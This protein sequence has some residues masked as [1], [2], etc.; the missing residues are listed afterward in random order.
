M[1]RSFILLLFLGLVRATLQN[2]TVDDASPDIVYD[3]P[4]FQCN[5]TICPDG[6]PEGLFNKSTTLTFGS[7][8]FSFTGTAFYGFLDLVGACSF[9]VDGNQ[10]PTLNNMTPSDAEQET[11]IVSKSDMANGPHTL[12]V[13]PI[14][15][16][17]IIGF[18]HLI[19]TYVKVRAR[20]IC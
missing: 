17:T 8:T 3:Q 7:I 6:S 4:T 9:N 14:T 2:Y 5:T 12:V 18:D 1:Q 16:G 15:N 20:A 13:A 19:Y 10:R 11:L